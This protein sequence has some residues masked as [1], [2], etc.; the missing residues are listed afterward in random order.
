MLPCEVED[1]VLMTWI[2]VC[3]ARGVPMDIRLIE[4]SWAITA[5]RISGVTLCVAHPRPN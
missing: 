3:S 2:Y 4:L 5:W 1:P